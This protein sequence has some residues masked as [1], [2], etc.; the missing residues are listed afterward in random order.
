MPPLERD[1]MLNVALPRLQMQ[2][3]IQ[4]RF[5]ALRTKARF[6]ITSR[7]SHGIRTPLASIVGFTELLNQAT[8][9]SDDDRNEF[10]RIIHAETSR[11]TRFVVTLRDWID[12]DEGRLRLQTT[13]SDLAES[14]RR[15]IEETKPEAMSRSVRLLN[16]VSPEPLC[17][18]AD[19]ERVR[20]AV[21][22][23]ILNALQATPSQGRVVVQLYRSLTSA[24]VTVSD[25]GVGI[26]AKDL[27][28]VANPFYRVDRQDGGESR[29]GL[30]LAMARGIAELH[31]GS[32]QVASREDHGTMVTMRFPTVVDRARPS[33][34]T[35]SH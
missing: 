12:I 3:D 20:I 7:I 33:G 13:P 11:L 17:L 34:F 14:V 21:E 32:M 26:P 8:P 10:H 16:A 35:C 27:P 5:A 15:A 9:I 4:V 1:P 25:T 19:H 29:L 24:T 22:Q 18:T 28:H 23:V 30:G 6:D 2:E 31:G